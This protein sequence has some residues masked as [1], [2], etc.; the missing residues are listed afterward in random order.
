MKICNKCGIEK[1]E[2]EFYWRVKN[3]NR[4]RD[5]KK[6]KLAQNK[7]YAQ[8]DEFKASKAKYAK[9]DKCK[10][11]QRAYEKTDKCKATRAKWHK[12]DKAK[13][14]QARNNAKR[15]AK[16]RDEFDDL[17]GEQLIQILS[18]QDY[19]CNGCK[20]SFTEEKP[21]TEDHI[22]PIGEGSGRTKDNIQ[23]LCASCNSIKGIKDMEYLFKRLKE[24][25]D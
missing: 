5:C 23:V 9:T 19:R 21:A 7:E 8:T 17:T 24:L 25:N 14:S 3:V 15:W 18:G 13:A 2:E 4:R 20:R 1:E 16:K 22:T 11:T 6:C 12:T 10:A